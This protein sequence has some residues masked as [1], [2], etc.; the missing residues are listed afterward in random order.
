MDE[1]FILLEIDKKGFDYYNSWIQSLPKNVRVHE[2][3]EDFSSLNFSDYSQMLD[4]VYPLLKMHKP[5]IDHWLSHFLFPKEAKEF[6]NRL[7]T[8]AWDLSS[9]NTNLTTGFSG[10]ND[11]SQYLLPLSMNYYELPGL[12]KIFL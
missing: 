6:K 5:V 2:S 7:S 12:G 3:V 10:T 4:Y 9:L 11:S 1:L 8:S